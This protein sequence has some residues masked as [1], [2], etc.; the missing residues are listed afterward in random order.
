MRRQPLPVIEVRSAL[1]NRI[2]L[3]LAA[4]FMMLGGALTAHS[5]EPTHAA[6]CDGASDGERIHEFG[7]YQRCANE[8]YSKLLTEVLPTDPVLVFPSTPADPDTLFMY[9]AATVPTGWCFWDPEGGDGAD[10]CPFSDY[11]TSGEDPGGDP[12]DPEAEVVDFTR[13]GVAWAAFFLACCTFWGMGKG[14][15]AIVSVVKRA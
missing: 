14:V 15:G 12:E 5:A 4:V 7:Q 11:W 6:V 13:S 9:S 8:R 3:V 1:L 2:A 10:F